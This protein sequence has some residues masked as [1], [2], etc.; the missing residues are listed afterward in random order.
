MYKQIDEKKDTCNLM[1]IFFI[2]LFIGSIGQIYGCERTSGELPYRDLPTWEPGSGPGFYFYRHKEVSRSE[3]AER[4]QRGRD[5]DNDRG[6]KYEKTPRARRVEKH[7]KAQKKKSKPSSP[8]VDPGAASKVIQD[9]IQKTNAKIDLATKPSAPKLTPPTPVRERESWDPSAYSKR[10]Y[11]IIQAPIIGKVISAVNNVVTIASM[12]YDIKKIVDYGINL[13]K[14]RELWGQSAYNQSESR[15]ARAFGLK[16]NDDLT[17]ADLS[18][19]IPFIAN[20]CNLPLLDKNPGLS[21]YLQD[22]KED[23][24][25]GVKEYLAGNA[26]LLFVSDNY[27]PKNVQVAL[28]NQWDIEKIRNLRRQLATFL[29]EGNNAI[30]DYD[31]LTACRS[32]AKHLDEEEKKRIER[33][34]R[35][36]D[37]DRFFSALLNHAL[38]SHSFFS[39]A[40]PGSQEFNNLMHVV[41]AHCMHA[42]IQS[43]S[44][45]SKNQLQDID[46]E[47]DHVKN[48]RLSI[49]RETQELTNDMQNISRQS[50]EKL[51]YLGQKCDEKKAEIQ[52]L[53]IKSYKIKAEL[54]T[55]RP[56]M[57]LAN[58]LENLSVHMDTK[59]ANI[60]DRIAKVRKKLLDLKR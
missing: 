59:Y 38:V 57:A 43:Q 36:P 33:I 41:M 34:L 45:R 28:L 37:Y 53:N 44:F 5:K 26:A 60:T 55:L 20:S 24:H 14:N 35:D 2:T 49:A 18:E 17:W 25:H 9:S 19:E 51:A 58:T 8:K 10:P 21:L 3:H 40:D 22:Y 1:S 39:S 47:C 46:K 27:K 12:A 42:V 13:K 32:R 29:Y 4:E 50:V 48:Q 7:K 16:I 15:E 54:E 11:P 23:I 31:V 30:L 6:Q 56:Q 52:E